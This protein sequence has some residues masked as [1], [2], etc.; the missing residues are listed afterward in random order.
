MAVARDALAERGFSNVEDVSAREPYDF[1]ATKDGEEWCI[2][3]KVRQVSMPI[4][5][6]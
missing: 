1:A 2:E 6:C 4:R 3:V 5:S